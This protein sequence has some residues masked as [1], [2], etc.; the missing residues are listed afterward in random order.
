MAVDFK[1][2]NILWKGYDAYI[3]A[4]LKAGLSPWAHNCFLF[5][6]LGAS[7]EPTHSRD[8][9]M[10]VAFGMVVPAPSHLH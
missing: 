1:F 10:D 3:L 6:G 7:R 9:H 5:I 4:A 8:F 2:G